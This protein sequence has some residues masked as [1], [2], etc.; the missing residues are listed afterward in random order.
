MIFT[1]KLQPFGP[2]G[3]SIWLSNVY[4]I[5]SYKKNEFH[6]YYLRNG[7]VN[8]GQYVDDP[9]D[10][11]KFRK[12]WKSFESAVRSCIKHTLIHTPD[13]GTL[14]TAKEIRGLYRLHDAEARRRERP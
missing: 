5:I 1:E 4:K 11:G 9:P 3:P 2:N 6:A 7:A 12:V 10:K 13:E 14:K 8:W